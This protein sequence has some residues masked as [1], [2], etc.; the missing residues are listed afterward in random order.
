[1]SR[2]RWMKLLRDLSL[3]RGRMMMLVAAIAASVFAVALMLSTFTVMTREMNANYLGT[4]PASAFIEVDQVDEAL[5]EAVRQQPNIADAEATAWVNGRVEVAPDQWM[6]LLLFVVP[7][8]AHARI[9]TVSPEA[10]AFPPPDGTILVERAVLTLLD[11]IQI[12]DALTV[13]TPNGTTQPITISG[14]IH[15]PS[16]APAWQEQTVYG[17]ITPGTLAAFGEDTTL[18]ILKITVSNQ[19]ESVSA[20][21]T[22]V[23]QLTGWLRTQGRVVDE[24]R[25]PPP[26]RHPHQ[27]Q[28]NTVMLVFLAFSVLALILSAVL[29]ATMIGGLLAQQIRQIGIMKAIGARSGQI[30]ALYLVLVMGLGLIAAV[31]GI[32]PGMWAARGFS[33]VVAQLL[34]LNV[35]RYDVPLWVYGALLLMGVLLPLLV[36]IRPIRRAT[37]VTVRATLSDYGTTAAAFGSSRFES[38]LSRIQ[39][40]NSSVLLAFRNTF[41]RRSRLILSLSLLGAAG[42][43]FMTG[44]NTS[45]GWDSYIRMAAADRHYDLEV[46]LNMPQS[47]EQMR[48][49]L[50]GVDGVAQVESWSLIP[51]AL[52]RP[53]GLDIVRTYP[54]GGHGSFSLRSVPDGSTFM[55]TPM[56]SGRWLQAGDVNRV[57]LNQSALALFPEASV[58]STVTLLIEGQPIRLEVIGVVRQI[59]SPAAAYV[60]PAT[61]AAAAHMQPNLA[62]AVRVAMTS[63][64]PEFTAAVTQR[65]EQALSLAGISVRV[66]VSEVLL[67]NATSGHVFVFIVTLLLIAVVMAVV[68]LLGLTSS[69]STSVIERTREFGI[70]RSIGA[71]SRTV[72]LNVISEGV[73]I[74]L[75]SYGIAVVV[76]LPLSFGMGAYLGEMSFRSPLPLIVAP[77]GLGLWLAILIL[78]STAASAFPAR[79]AAN[80]TVRET[81]AYV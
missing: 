56:L 10:G 68:G 50:G 8:F 75:M 43:M 34:N 13:Q 63:S 52:A 28:M 79:Q 11:S 67:D 22:T 6:P 66:A 69:M 60:T 58:G 1:M 71:R 36:A 76:S 74:G 19:P 30:A 70:M 54:D 62:N 12:G 9:S 80:L 7:D 37:R 16:L 64:A 45:S 23:E 18:H 3:A 35:Y 2:P 31:I 39:G 33:S 61:F 59:L 53:N 41:R 15:D 4:N 24:I 57:V 38:W 48:A 27:S 20:I 17:Y 77:L 5:I 81:L 65:I 26:L 25:I 21:E 14:T 44:L 49:L 42:G 47:V 32:L 73:M 51:A 78:G 72:L 40:I 46:R 29:T 55:N